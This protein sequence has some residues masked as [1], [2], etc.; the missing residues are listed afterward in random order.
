M[1]PARRYFAARA[2]DPQVAFDTGVRPGRNA[3]EL[4]FPNG[5]RRLLRE[6]R[7]LQAKGKPLEAWWLMDRQPDA[8]TALICEGESDSLAALTALANAPDA[9]GLNGLPILCVPGTGF[10]IPRLV[11]ALHRDWKMTTALIGMDPDEA[12]EKFAAEATE[13]LL[14]KSIRPVRV[15]VPEPDLAGWLVTVEEAERG[16][17]LANLLIDSALAAPSMDALKRQ[18]EAA[19]LRAKADALEAA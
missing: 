16:E 18:R 14:D 8:K 1:T 10:P 5:R 15:D 17:R 2:I 19:R 6:E 11:S 9:S 3:N 12:G 4:A 13:A 7:V